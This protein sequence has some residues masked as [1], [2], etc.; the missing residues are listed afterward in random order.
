MQPQMQQ[1][2]A[3]KKKNNTMIIV[4]IVAV[5]AIVVIAVLALALMGGGGGGGSHIT[6]T[7]WTTNKDALTAYTAGEVTFTVDLKNTGVVSGTVNI[8]CKL[9]FQIGGSIETT[10]A[11]TV[12]AGASTSEDIDVVATSFLQWAQFATA[13]ATCTIV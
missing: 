11:V 7:N 2:G 13:T 4:A 1:P 5:I 6:I 10:K 8:K 3:P 9:T 12:A